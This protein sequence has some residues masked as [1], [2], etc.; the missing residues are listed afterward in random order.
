MN[1]RRCILHHV[2]YACDLTDNSLSGDSLSGKRKHEAN[3]GCASVKGLRKE[4]EPLR[5]AL[6]VSTRATM[7]AG[8]RAGEATA[9]QMGAKEERARMGF[10]ERA[11]TGRAET[12]AIAKKDWGLWT[13]VSQWSACTGWLAKETR[14][15]QDVECI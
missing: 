10:A 11:V 2:E 9:G 15:L 14:G 6:V 3:H 4:S 1:E 5:D 8:R 12:N 13:I 7:T